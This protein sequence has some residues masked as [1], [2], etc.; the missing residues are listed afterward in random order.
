MAPKV[1]ASQE[2]IN[3]LQEREKGFLSSVCVTLVNE[4]RKETGDSG[5]HHWGCFFCPIFHIVR[6]VSFR[7]FLHTRLERARLAKKETVRSILNV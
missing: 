7:A 1:G 6:F 4:V 5:L 2:R 3:E